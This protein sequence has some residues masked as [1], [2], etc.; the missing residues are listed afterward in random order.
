MFLGS[1]KAILT[2]RLWCDQRYNWQYNRP[3]TADCT[4][5]CTADHTVGMAYLLGNSATG[6]RGDHQLKSSMFDISIV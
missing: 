6:Q 4:T 3:T 2:K 1:L 5:D